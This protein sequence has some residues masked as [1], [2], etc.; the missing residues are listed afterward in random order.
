MIGE[1]LNKLKEKKDIILEEFEIICKNF[2][3][4]RFNENL[5]K[6]C[7]R[8]H[9]EISLITKEIDILKQALIIYKKYN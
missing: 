1:T 7:D 9:E 2:S 6:E 3:Q 8:K 4:D 5:K